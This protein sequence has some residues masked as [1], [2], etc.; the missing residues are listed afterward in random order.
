MNLNQVTL[1]A[2]DLEASIAFYTLL[3]LRRIVYA[4]P[5]YARFECPVGD[6]TFSLHASETKVQQAACVIYFECDQLD[7][8][9]ARL[10]EAGITFKQLPQDESW[11]WRESRLLDPSGNE[12]CLYQAGINRRFPPWREATSLPS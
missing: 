6:A 8:E 4:P 7:R 11:L 12:I 1:A 10:R 3:G 5:R 2:H 9:V